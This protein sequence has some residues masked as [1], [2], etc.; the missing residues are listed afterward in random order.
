MT[1]YQFWIAYGVYILLHYAA[2]SYGY[3]LSSL[4]EREE[5]AVQVAPTIL[6]PLLL[7]SGFVSNA[8]TLPDWIGWLQWLSPVRYAFESLVQNEF[9]NREYLPGEVNMVTFFAFELGIWKCVVISIGFATFLRI[10]S[11]IMLKLLVNKFQ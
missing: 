3:F 6:I 7:F 4:F 10:V 9:G 2:S 8:G 5:T 11:I 1:A